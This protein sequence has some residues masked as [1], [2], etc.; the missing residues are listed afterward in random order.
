MALIKSKQIEGGGAGGTLSGEAVVT[1]PGLPAVR[2]WSE[3]VVAAGVTALNKIA[4]FLAPAA[5][6]DENEP[7][8]L[9]LVALSAKAGAGNI[10]FALSFSAPT[11][12][13]V[14]LLWKVL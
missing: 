12:G 3:N 13:P 9:D 6:S 8:M 7:E 10:T 14:K 2:E 1:L 4:A 5:D 11:S